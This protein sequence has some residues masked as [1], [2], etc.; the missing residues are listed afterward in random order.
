MH[1]CS[2]I[3]DITATNGSTYIYAGGLVGKNK[4]TNIKNCYAKCNVEGNNIAGIVANGSE[5]SANITISNCYFYGELSATTANAYGIA[6]VSNSTYKFTIDHCYYPTSY[7]LCHTPSPDN[8][9]NATLSSGT[10]ISGGSE[11]SLRDA[12]N[13]NINNMPTG[14]YTWKNS[15]DNTYVV[16]NI[17][18]AKK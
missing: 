11:T 15:N 9:N 8:G 3:G 5:L 17:P 18:N 14:S 6:G 12:L 13:A 16:F 4:N 1:N 2:S 7:S 10:T